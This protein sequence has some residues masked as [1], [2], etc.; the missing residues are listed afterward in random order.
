MVYHRAAIK[1]EV[2]LEEVLH[3]KSVSQC[4]ENWKLMRVEKGKFH[5]MGIKANKN[6]NY[7]T[8]KNQE[9]RLETN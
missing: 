1:N 6:E 2:K 9:F 5:D 7:K 3:Y 8:M 4:H